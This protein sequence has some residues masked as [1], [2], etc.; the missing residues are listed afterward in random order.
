MHHLYITTS[1]VSPETA[2]KINK[3]IKQIDPDAEFVGPVYV[4]GSRLTG[5]IQRP[6]DGTNGYP[7]VKKRNRAMAQI[8]CEELSELPSQQDES[9]LAQGR[10]ATREPIDDPHRREP[11][12]WDDYGR[13]TGGE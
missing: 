11:G 5:W 4:P 1:N 8:A 12:A 9:A 2:F 3:R 7:E 13:F 10:A 6:D